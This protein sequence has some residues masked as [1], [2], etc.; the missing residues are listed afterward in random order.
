MHWG[1][2][3]LFSYIFFF[4]IF[5]LLSHNFHCLIQ[6]LLIYFIIF[7]VIYYFY[8]YHHLNF[9][10]YFLLYIY[11]TAWV[12]YFPCVSF[13]VHTILISL[14][15]CC[16]TL[17]HISLAPLPLKFLNAVNSIQTFSHFLVVIFMI[18]IVKSFPFHFFCFVHGLKCHHTITRALQT[19]TFCTDFFLHWV[20]V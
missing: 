8:L 15:L 7:I 18:I 1:G 4:H 20:Q 10:F 2:L 9:S 11:S 6:C 17:F 3:S 16:L 19:V 5:V 14:W 12:F 13:W